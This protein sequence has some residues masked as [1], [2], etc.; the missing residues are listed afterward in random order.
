M[1]TTQV[2][3]IPPTT[4]G[5]NLSDT[6][7]MY[8]LTIQ[9]LAPLYKVD[10]SEGSYSEELPPAGLNQST[11]QSA[12]CKEIVYRKVS[13]DSNTF[14]LLGSEDGPL[15]LTAPGPGAV[16]RLKSDA[17]GWWAV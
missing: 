11:G 13:Q 17:T 6:D 14:T 9:G 3:P 10:T 1:P 7:H 12:Q 4:R 5:S 15:T 16:L 2:L 8:L